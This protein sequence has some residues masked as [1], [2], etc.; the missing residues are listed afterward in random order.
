M[1]GG[2]SL[3]ASDEEGK[4]P[5]I[6]CTHGRNGERRAHSETDHRD[7]KKNRSEWDGRRTCVRTAHR[8]GAKKV[9]C[10]LASPGAMSQPRMTPLISARGRQVR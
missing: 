8:D 2:P 10:D 6:R 1:G 4:R 7:G 9:E 5:A 3:E